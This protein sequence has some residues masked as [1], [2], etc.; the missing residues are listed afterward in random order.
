MIESIFG[1]SE[2]SSSYGRRIDLIL[3]VSHSKKRV[4]ISSNEWKKN[5]TSQEVV[6]KQQCKNLRANACIIQQIMTRY[7]INTSVMAMDFVG[8]CGC[9]YMIKK[10]SEQVFVAKPV[11][12]LA[13]PHHIDHLNALKPTLNALFQIKSFLV[14]QTRSINEAMFELDVSNAL[15]SLNFPSLSITSA[16]TIPTPYRFWETKCKNEPAQK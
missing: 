6:Q 1:L 16:S 7:K 5:A 4:E 8:S 2:Q 11:A 3:G 12:R 15:P 13:T 9:L 10:T 14:E